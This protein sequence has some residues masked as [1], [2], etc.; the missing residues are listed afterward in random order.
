LSGR[1][2]AAKN[3]F[4]KTDRAAAL[5]DEDF[6]AWT[7]SQAREL[8][9]F[10]RTRPNVALDVKHIA[11]E[12]ADLGMSGATRCAAGRRASSSICCCSSIHRR[13]SRAAAGSTRS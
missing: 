7:G 6:F 8:R 12:I 10:A 3:P 9:R 5:H 1:V 11:E 13:R 2:G 4:M